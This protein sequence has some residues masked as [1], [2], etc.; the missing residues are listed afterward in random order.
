M[1]EKKN[2]Y[3]TLAAQCE[4]NTLTPLQTGWY[5][6]VLTEYMGVLWINLAQGGVQWQS[7]KQSNKCLH[8]N[9][10]GPAKWCDFQ[11]KPIY[12]PC[13]SE[14]VC[15]PQKA[16]TLT[17]PDVSVSFDSICKMLTTKILRSFSLPI[18]WNI[19]L[20]YPTN[21]KKKAKSRCVKITAKNGATD[22][23]L[24]P[25]QSITWNFICTRC[26]T[27]SFHS[28]TVTAT[29]HWQANKWTKCGAC[30]ILPQCT[31]L[32]KLWLFWIHFFFCMEVSE[33]N[34]LS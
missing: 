8:F 29:Q 16:S 31:Q 7:Y 32:L 10:C 12:T 23:S 34:C 14:W 28:N 25:V 20:E 33:T 5:W 3:T 13:V 18:M 27:L 19:F 21:K 2:A 24:R 4:G 15:L 6:D 30:W 17:L 11:R 1:G 9:S 26:R 22:A